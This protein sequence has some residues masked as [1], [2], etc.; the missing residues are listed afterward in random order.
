VLVDEGG[1][2]VSGKVSATLMVVMATLVAGLM[3]TG[4]VSGDATTLP[5]GYADLPETR[6]TELLADGVTLTR[7]V[8]GDKPARPKDIGTTRRGP[9]RVN[10]LTIDPTVATGRLTA[11]YGPDLAR[12][13]TVRDIA[14][15]SGALAAVNA[16]YFT[17]GADKLFPGNPVGVGIY[18]G[19]L[20]SEPEPGLPAE[21]A[22]L[23]DDR[24][25]SISIDRLTWQGSVVNR[26]TGL[27][28][29]LE[30]L[31]SPPV[32]PKA[33]RDL[34]KPTKCG[35]DGDVVLLSSG[36]SATTPAG[37]GVEVVLGRRGCVVRQRLER[38][39]VLKPQQTSLQ[40]T[41][42]RTRRLVKMTTKPACL[43]TVSLLSNSVGEPIE[44]GPWLSG[45][46][47]RFR[48][49]V[50]G[51]T[52]FHRGTESL[53]HRHPRTIAGRTDTGAI[54]IATI[55]GRS[56]TSVGTTLVETAKV[57]S[58]LGMVDSI[59]LDGG[60]STTM[61]VNGALANVPS[62]SGERAVGDALVYVPAAY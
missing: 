55:D 40:A 31:N 59:N 41:G 37:P 1:A 57:A 62:G 22:L 34:K 45:V 27:G 47:G 38:G 28:L 46:N 30:S 33:C 19:R 51:R 18:D 35:E 5:L 9:W 3:G 20:M 39:T 29:D 10:V 61:V 42:R 15:F 14:A 6:T 2:D 23:M 32:V 44:T 12:T 13:E 50:A 11:S 49:T 7:I 8:R 52:M 58:A 60:G 16:S 24:T 48:L 43:D 17:F 4:P 54:V 21:V 53:Y 36:F 25:K 26:D 56:T